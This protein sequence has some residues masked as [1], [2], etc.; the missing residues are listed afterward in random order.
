MLLIGGEQCFDAFDN[1]P[2]SQVSKSILQNEDTSDQHADTLHHI[3]DG[4]GAKASQHIVQTADH[5]HY[6]HDDLD[7]RKIADAQ[8]LVDMENAIDGNGA[9]IQYCRDE[10]Y[11]ITQEKDH[12]H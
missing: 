10:V 6:Q 8:R 7:G 4:D 1:M 11:K 12:R 5:A 3:L 2:V 9:T